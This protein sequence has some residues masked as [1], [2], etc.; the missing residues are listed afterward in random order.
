[1]DAVLVGVDADAP[2]AER[3]RLFQRAVAAE[4]GDLED[5]LG[6]G[7]DLVL[8]HRR[9]LAL[10]GEAVRVLRDR[11]RARDRLVGAVLVTRDVRVDRRDLDSADRA[12]DLLAHLLGLLRCEDADETA[13]F[14]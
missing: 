11:L 7:A 2:L 10:V 1:R 4:A 14:L 5:H 8:R 13:A 6:S 9:A 3:G 12:D